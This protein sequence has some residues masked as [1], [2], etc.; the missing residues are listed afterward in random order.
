[1]EA[2]RKTKSLFIVFKR[3]L[4]DV[5]EAPGF[6]RQ[7]AKEEPDKTLLLGLSC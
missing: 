1:M 5:E 6:V 2:R 7:K 3:V 4:M